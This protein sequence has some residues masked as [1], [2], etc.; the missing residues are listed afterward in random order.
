MPSINTIKFLRGRDTPATSDFTIGDR[1]Q[2]H[3]ATDL[4]ARGARFGDVVSVGR[5]LVRVHVDALGRT[6]CIDP[7]NLMHVA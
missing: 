2:L 6:I 7:A 4:W 1:V 5:K 3:P